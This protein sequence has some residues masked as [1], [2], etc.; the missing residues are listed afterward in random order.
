MKTHTHIQSYIHKGTQRYAKGQPP[1][2]MY[3]S[4]TMPERNANQ[5]HNQ[6]QN[7]NG[8]NEYNPIH[9]R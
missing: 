8:C 6:N 7:A 3:Y 5:M 9:T 4:I 1:T 2:K